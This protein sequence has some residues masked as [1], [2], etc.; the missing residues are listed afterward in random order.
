M[1]LPGQVRH[2]VKYA[3]HASKC[4][5]L[6]S[7]QVEIMKQE[8]KSDRVKS[9]SEISNRH[10]A[11][12]IEGCTSWRHHAVHEDRAWLLN[13]IGKIHAQVDR[14]KTARSTGQG[15]D[16]ELDALLALFEEPALDHIGD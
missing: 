16:R 10:A 6:A 14:V 3:Y 7:V 13:A 1:S 2:P 5:L 4:V 12:E 15:I 8:F 11:R 9:L